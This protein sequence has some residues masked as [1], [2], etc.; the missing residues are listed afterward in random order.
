MFLLERPKRA[1]LC[2]NDFAHR[3]ALND[4]SL[5]VFVGVLTSTNLAKVWSCD[6]NDFM[7]EDN[8][9]KYVQTARL[10]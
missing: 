1:K 10:E 3:I 4:R 2:K 8:F 7:P 9:C 6:N 5:V